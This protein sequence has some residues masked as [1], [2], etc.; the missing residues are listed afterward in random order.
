M[1]EMKVRRKIGLS[2]VLM[3][4]LATVLIGCSNKEEASGNQEGQAGSDSNGE[5][6]IMMHFDGLEFPKKDNE[7]EKAIEE[8]TDT[9]LDISAAPGATVAEKLPAVVASG[10]MPDIIGSSWFREPYMVNAFRGDVFWE[11]GPYLD[12]FPNLSSIDPIIY[13]NISIDGKIYGLPRVRPIARDVYIYRKDWLDNLGM[14]EPKTVDEF[15]DMLDAFTN[16]D[17]DQNGKDD[18]YGMTVEGQA[19]INRFAPLFGAPNGWGEENGK[20]FHAATTKEYLDGL[21]FF[22]KLYDDKL[23]TQDFAVIERSQWEEAFSTGKAGVWP[24][25][26]NAVV[27]MYNRI[28]ETNPDVELGVFSLLEGP[29]GKRVPAGSGHNGIFVF[30]KSSVKTEKELLDL[31]GFFEK[32]QEEPMHTLFEWGIEGMHYELVDGKPVPIEGS[33]LHN[34]VILPYQLP[35]GI[36]PAEV[37]ALKGE[38][39]PLE[40]KELEIPKENE[41]FAIHNPAV[42]LISDT[43]SE[44][45]SQLNTIIEDANTKYIMGEIDADEWK[46]QIKNWRSSGGDQIAEEYAKEYKK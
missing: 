32:L 21:D 19:L 22:K 30:P 1:P 34:E 3:I 23:I 15:Y 44:K 16:K 24:D 27:R 31:L 18:T 20:F 37:N 29:Q 6:S 43:Q 14:K 36:V 17:P 9:K 40:T 8:Y 26:S 12:Q 33:D 2:I 41:P 11:I 5:V 13:E 39:T 46:E 38:L 25:T 28:K 4:V 45:G 10:D 7:V 35:L 42:N